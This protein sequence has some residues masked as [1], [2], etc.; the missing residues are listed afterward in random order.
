MTETVRMIL[1]AGV[2]FLAAALGSIVAPFIKARHDAKL[3]RHKALLAREARLYEKQAPIVAELFGHI[4]GVYGQLV[5]SYK[6]S[7]MEGEDREFYKKD[8][9]RRNQELINF[10]SINEL[11]LPPQIVQTCRELLDEI[12]KTRILIAYYEMPKVAPAEPGWVQLRTKI[13]DD[14]PP[15]VGRAEEECRIF[16]RSLV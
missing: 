16:V 11:Y 15:I 6:G 8:F 5:Q 3:E 9:A 10:F 4:R 7:Y 12:V 1:T 2:T 14:L 13:F